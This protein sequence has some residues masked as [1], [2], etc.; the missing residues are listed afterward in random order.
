M[1]EHREQTPHAFLVELRELAGENRV[2][3]AGLRLEVSE[4]RGESRRRLEE[5][6][7]QRFGRERSDAL[8]P[9]CR[10]IR[11]ESFEH[12]PLGGNARQRASRG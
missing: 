6:D 8:A 4:G 12:E 5:D 10:S 7:R 9:L 2:A 3:I 1:P 11:Q